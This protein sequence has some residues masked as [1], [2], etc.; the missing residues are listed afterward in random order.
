M[1]LRTTGASLERLGLTTTSAVPACNSLATVSSRD[2]SVMKIKGSSGHLSRA[3]SRAD[4]PSNFGRGNSARIKSNPPF[5]SA[6]TKSAR[7]SIRRRSQATP[8]AWSLNCAN[9]ALSGWCSRWRMRIGL[10][11]VVSITLLSFVECAADDPWTSPVPCAHPCWLS[12][13]E[14]F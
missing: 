1:V 3:I 13:N 7:F 9:L 4:G 2:A 5:S 12:N 11:T 10:F 8:W 14:R 6:E